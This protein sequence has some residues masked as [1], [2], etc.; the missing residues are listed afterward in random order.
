MHLTFGINKNANDRINKR[1]N[2][3]EALDKQLSK[4]Y[5][6][7]AN[8]TPTSFWSPLTNE[9]DLLG[10]DRRIQNRPNGIL[11]LPAQ[12]QLD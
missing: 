7:G 12:E 11:D 4:K 5:V 9:I 10:F 2:H 6:I 8:L 1:N 3:S